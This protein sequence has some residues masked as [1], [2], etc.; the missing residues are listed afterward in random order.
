[1][2]M[3]SDVF[4]DCSNSKNCDVA[5]TDSVRDPNTYPSVINCSASLNCNVDLNK[6]AASYVKCDLADSCT[7]SITT[8]TTTYSSCVTTSPGK[9]F[10]NLVDC[11][12]SVNTCSVTCDDSVFCNVLCT[13][14][15]DC[16]VTIKNN[17][18]VPSLTCGA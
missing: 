3:G 10:F 6:N 13:G 12:N 14:A 16:Q 1:M 17:L 18:L 15:A 7:V 11:T 4:V 9:T 2:S 8:T 5:F